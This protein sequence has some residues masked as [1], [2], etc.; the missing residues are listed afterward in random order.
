M[1]SPLL[2][3]ESLGYRPWDI[4]EMVVLRESQ[5]PRLVVTEAARRVGM[6]I[7]TW[8]ELWNGI[9]EAL[10]GATV[11]DELGISMQVGTP[12]HGLGR[13]T[14]DVKDIGY[15]WVVLERVS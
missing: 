4:G 14:Y 15:G 9:P 6:F 7:E 2:G 1:T 13:V 3:S 12:G 8:Q 5:P 11:I 10:E